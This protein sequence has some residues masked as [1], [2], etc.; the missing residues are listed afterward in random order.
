MNWRICGRMKTN[1][2][3][4]NKNSISNHPIVLWG[5]TMY[6]EIAY[7]VITEVYN[8][9][10]EAVI[11]NKFVSVPWLHG[12]T[13]RSKELKRYKSIDL[14]ICAANSFSAIYEEAKRYS[15]SIV[16]YDLKDILQDYQELCKVNPYMATSSYMYGDIDIDEICQRYCYYAGDQNGYDEKLYLPYCVLCV[17]TKC[18]L[19]CKECA[20][21]ITKYIHHIDYE[22][23][24]LTSDFEQI[25]SAIDGIMEL[26]IMGG[27]P[28]L[29]DEINRILLWCIIHPKIHAVK[30]VT[31][32]TIVPKQDTWEILQ[33]KKIK[34]VIDDYG[35]LSKNLHVIEQKAKEYGVLYEKQL[36]QTWYQLSPISP[37]KMSVE[38]LKRVY[39]GCNFKSCIGMT[40]GRFYHC[41]VAGHM[42]NTG[43]TPQ[44]ENDY[45]QIQGRDWKTKELRDML[46][47]FLKCDYLESCDYCNYC[48]HKE[49]AVAEQDYTRIE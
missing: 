11:D 35:E 45:L 4:F 22:W 48:I 12:K 14:L 2:K 19:K 29:H 37:K 24:T 27:E 33:S 26:E 17:T 43:Q 15:E 39:S 25:L 21:F 41:N 8:G 7:K 32:G 44:M 49:V 20:A 28:F 23:T 3:S 38:Q 31:N 42:M 9:K 34:L 5:G 18:S 46:K 10:V 1:I 16:I 36:L 40:N 6:G 47:R 30:I 13:V